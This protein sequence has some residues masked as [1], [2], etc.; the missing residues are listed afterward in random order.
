[1][2]TQ[3]AI[4]RWN[5]LIQEEIER[6]LASF[7]DLDSWKQWWLRAYWF[8]R[9]KVATKSDRTCPKPTTV[10]AELRLIEEVFGD[11]IGLTSND[12][13]PDITTRLEWLKR[14]VG[15]EF[16][17][18]IKVAIDRHKITS[19]IE[20]IFLMEWRVAKLDEKYGLTLKP[21]KTVK[22]AAG[23]FRVDF[24]VTRANSKGPKL[25]IAIELD[26]H[27]FHEKS[28]GQVT[29]DKRRERAIVS[30]GLTVLR[31]SGS[32]VVFR[33]RQCVAEV[34]EYI[35]ARTPQTPQPQNGA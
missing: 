2:L 18:D 14:R 32:E 34:E 28:K 10:E 8:K 6:D 25:H 35:S 33:P 9:M 4:R 13:K 3:L 1:M 31:F 20:Q 23:D 24:L 7:D 17:R 15:K 11:Q 21:Q 12:L 19:P 5:E 29:G 30:A 26:G 27:I 16:E 22:T